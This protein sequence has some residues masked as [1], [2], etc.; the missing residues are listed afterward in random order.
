MRR[1]PA[2]GTIVNAGRYCV[3]K[4]PAE[5]LCIGLGSCVAISLH[6]GRHHIGSLAHAMLPRYCQGRDRRNGGKYVD[7]SV[8]LMVDELQDMGVGKRFLEAKLV[9]GAH[10]F[11]FLDLDLFDIG[12]RNVEAAVETLGSEGIPIA[13]KD[14]GGDAGRTIRFDIKTGRIRIQTSGNQ[15]RHI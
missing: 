3:A 13:A 10:M 1:E 14:V 9:G 12:K 6:S 7:T 15:V 2:D 8:Y 5:L 4:N 11:S